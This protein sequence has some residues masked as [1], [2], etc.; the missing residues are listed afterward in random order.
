MKK[1]M[2]ISIFA[3]IG[4]ILGALIVN[5]V[6]PVVTLTGPANNAIDN[7]GEVIFEYSVTDDLSNVTQCQL[8]TNLSGVWAADGAANTN[9]VIGANSFT[10]T[11]LPDMSSFDWNVE[12]TDN[13]V[14]ALSSFALS[15]RTVDINYQ[16]L[17][18]YSL[19]V[20]VDGDSHSGID[21]ED[22][23]DDVCDID[24]EVYPDSEIRVLLKFENIYDE[25]DY[26]IEIENIEVEA[27]LEEID[28]GDDIDPEDEPND[29]D[30]DAEEK[31]EVELIFNIPLEVEEDEYDLIINVDAEDEDGNDQSFNFQFN[32][33]VDKKSHKIIIENAEFDRDV[34]SCTRNTGLDVQIMNIGSRDENEIEMSVENEELGIDILKT[35]VPELMSDAYDDDNNYLAS[36]D[37]DVGDD[38]A[39]GTY[40]VAVTVY[41]SGDVHSDEVDVDLTVQNCQTTQPQV[42][43]EEE[44]EEEVIIS[45]P[46]NEP[47]PNY[48]LDEFGITDSVETSFK[49]SVSYTV[50]LIVGIIVALGSIGLMVVLLVKK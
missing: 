38:I 17:I 8:W 32:V 46:E 27:V 16:K 18:L 39:A 13:E 24:D 19:K 29:F 44:E 28:D 45:E 4:L 43:E 30:L 26:D 6:A 10:R 1:S 48:I 21:E 35:N 15:N 47:I 25:D 42:D 41:Y 12:C 5:S 33:N 50:L 11:A 36:F 37:I 49:D 23:V 22:C 9:I 40:P 7:D 31:E 3:V 34:L 20:Y 14:P 2:L